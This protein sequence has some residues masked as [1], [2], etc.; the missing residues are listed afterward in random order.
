[1]SG[2]IALALALTGALAAS[3]AAQERQ[4]SFDTSGDDAYLVFGVPDTDDIGVSFWCAMGSGEIRL[5]IPAAG[6]ILM[7]DEPIAFTVTVGSE[8]FNLSGRSTPN[9]EAGG[10]SLEA[11]LTPAHPLFEALGEAD[12]FKLETGGQ[13]HIYPLADADLAG[14]QRLCRKP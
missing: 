13:E 14:L 11:I 2:R 4:W 6:E 7:P 3:A 9:E 5:F 10:T 8:I 12:R 1:M